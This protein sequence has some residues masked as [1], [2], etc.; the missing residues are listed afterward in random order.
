MIRAG[1]G[2]PLSDEEKK[3]NRIMSSIRAHVEHPY[4]AIRR[5]FHFIRIYVTTIKR[6]S[7]KAL[8]MCIN[9][10]L[11]RALFLLKKSN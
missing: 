9:Y 11:M 1:R 2:H 10:N 4:A 5:S 3:V 7:V 6:V 8:F